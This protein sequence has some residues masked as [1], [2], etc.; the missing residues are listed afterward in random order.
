MFRIKG[1]RN[2]FSQQANFS[3]LLF[4]DFFISWQTMRFSWTFF[5]YNKLKIE[6][7]LD[8]QELSAKRLSKNLVTAIEKKLF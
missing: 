2:L 5:Q 7:K 8:S 1:Q 6:K 4:R 3:R